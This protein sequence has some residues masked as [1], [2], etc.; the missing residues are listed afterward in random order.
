MIQYSAISRLAV[1]VTGVIFLSYKLRPSDS[2]SGT[3]VDSLG[4]TTLGLIGCVSFVLGA[5]C[6]AAAG[7]VSMWVAARSNIRVASAARRSY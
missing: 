6:S 7:Y 4:S 1:V 2:Q 5:A 3:G